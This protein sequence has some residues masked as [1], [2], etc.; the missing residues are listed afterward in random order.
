MPESEARK[1]WQREN[2]V[3]IGLKLQKSTDG[4]I[5]AFLQ[6]KQNQTVF[7]AAIREYMERH[8]DEQPEKSDS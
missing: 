7:K 4:D 1:K 5:L 8:P 2:T 6:G 3:H